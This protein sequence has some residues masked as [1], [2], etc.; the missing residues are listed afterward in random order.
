MVNGLTSV[1][2]RRFTRATWLE[3]V[4]REATSEALSA[5][6][7]VTAAAARAKRIAKVVIVNKI[8]Y[9]N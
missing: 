8:K 5:W 6:T 1:S 7:V 3:A 9:E 4:L 2:L